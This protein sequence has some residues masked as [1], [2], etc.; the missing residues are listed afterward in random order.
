MKRFT[1]LVSVLLV[2][3][4]HLGDHRPLNYRAGITTVG[5][6]VCIIVPVSDDE[7]MTSLTIS[8]VG[9]NLNVTERHFTLEKGL[10]LSAS[11]CVPDFGFSF[12]SGRS[13]IS[14]IHT[15]Y[16][17]RKDSVPNGRNYSVTFSLWKENGELKS[18][19]VN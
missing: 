13:Y 1:L 6:H 17:N 4:C 15:T 12:E 3:S 11:T 10:T 14:S 5:N 19:D 7:V 16:R 8:E 2:T 9:N 18:V